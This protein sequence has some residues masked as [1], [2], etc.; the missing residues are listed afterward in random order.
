[1]IEPSDLYD[2]DLDPAFRDRTPRPT[3]TRGGSRASRQS[4]STH[5]RVRSAGAG[6]TRRSAAT[7]LKEYAAARFD[8]ASQLRA[9]DAQGLDIAVLFRTLPVVCVDAFDPAFALALCQAWN[10]WAADFRKPSPGALT[11]ERPGLDER[12][13]SVSV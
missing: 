7:V 2:H 1:M 5:S 12:R 11:H 6:S 9:M 13:S 10:D 4:A 8:S 3:A